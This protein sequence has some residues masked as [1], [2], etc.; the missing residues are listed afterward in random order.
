[1]R[2]YERPRGFHGARGKET[3]VNNVFIEYIEKR[4]AENGKER[5]DAKNKQNR[6]VF[7]ANAGIG[8]AKPENNR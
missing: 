3:I 8:A 4:V 1:M 2:K 6:A 7:S 5:G